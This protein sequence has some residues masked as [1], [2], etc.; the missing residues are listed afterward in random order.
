MTEIED[1]LNIINKKTPKELKELVLNLSKDTVS[2]SYALQQKKIK[3]ID[4][5]ASWC[6]PC[7]EEIIRSKDKREQIASKYNVV[8]LYISLD[9]ETQ[10]WVDKSIDLYQ[11]LPEGQQFKI[12]DQKKSKLIKFLNLERSFGIAIPRYIILDE[13]NKI[14]DNNAPKPSIDK[15]EEIIK[16]MNI[17]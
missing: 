10:K 4:F 15:F 12:L 8:F 9:K 1:E 17:D 16:N 7:I 13:N 5:W 3:V 11:F 6:H 2:F 14:I